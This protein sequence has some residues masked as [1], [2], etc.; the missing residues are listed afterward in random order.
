MF[1]FDVTKL[2]KAVFSAILT[3]FFGLNSLT[4]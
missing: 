1:S 2:Y 4:F 3:L